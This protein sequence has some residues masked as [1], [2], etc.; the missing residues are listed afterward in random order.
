[1]KRND[2][3]Y[4]SNID[5]IDG[6]VYHTFKITESILIVISKFDGEEWKI[7]NKLIDSNLAKTLGEIID[8][9][10]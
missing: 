10:Q 6:F 1:M 5:K 7:V 8:N 9:E 4:H 3:E 2:F